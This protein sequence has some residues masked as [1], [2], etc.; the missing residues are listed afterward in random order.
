MRGLTKRGRSQASKWS[1]I[2]GVVRPAALQAATNAFWSW[3]TETV[4]ASGT[5][6]VAP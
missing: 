1:S 6:M 4:S 5:G 3:Q 2:R